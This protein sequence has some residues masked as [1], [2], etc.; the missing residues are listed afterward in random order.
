[1]DTYTAVGDAVAGLTPVEPLYVFR[2][3]SL[4]KAA[5]W[6]LDNFRGRVLYAV[7]TNPDPYVLKGLYDA[8][9]RDFDVASLAEVR[10]V[11]ETL[12]DVRLC[13]MHTVKAREAI[14]ASYRDFGVRAF[15]LDCE[16]EL[17][18]I[19]AAT[20]HAR[21]LDLFVRIAIPST[22]S[23]INL[24]EKFGI[25]GQQALHLLVEARK[26]SKRLG[27]CFHVGSQCMN[28]E[29]YRMAI[30][31]VRDLLHQAGVDAD[32][33]DVGGGFPSAYPGM[34]PPPLQ[35][36]M[37]AIHGCIDDLGLTDKVELWCEP[38]RALVAESGA[39]VVRVELRKGQRLYI[40]DGTYG[41][42]FDAGVPGFTF[43][44]RLIRVSGS[45]ASAMEPFQFYGP[46]C[47]S[48]DAMNGPFHLPADVREG[49]YIQIDQLGAYGRTFR[50]NFNG[51]G[52]DRVVSVAEEAGVTMYGDAPA[53]AEPWSLP[54]EVTKKPRRAA[55]IAI[56]K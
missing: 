16:A 26:A 3:S 1:M 5:H 31:T 33:I 56:R 10:L 44:A 27:V 15:S 28:P 12:S 9:V 30:E 21:D 48:M 52:Y 32:V 2:P 36:Y 51:F 19:L 14:A 53:R 40:N 23:K 47:D 37:D 46:T 8:G 7:K 39:V 22:H 18:K 6:F 50:T 11:R 45:H 20:G 43:P 34:T 55:R 29:A 4:R 13:F 41:A 25:W 54:L 17:D 35:C 24:A 42:L 38:G 49:D